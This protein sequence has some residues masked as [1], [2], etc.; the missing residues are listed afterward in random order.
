MGSDNIRQSSGIINIGDRGQH[1]GYLLVLLDK[2]VKMEE[3]RTS[4][5]QVPCLY[6]RLSALYAY[7]KMGSFCVYSSIRTVRTFHQ[8]PHSAVGHL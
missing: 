4:K 3:S 6:R 8:Y 5:P 2:L 7:P 1:L